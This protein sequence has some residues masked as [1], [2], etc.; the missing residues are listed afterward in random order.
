MQT[1]E[2]RAR[3]TNTQGQMPRGIKNPPMDEQADE[4]TKRGKNIHTED[5]LQRVSHGVYFL[6]SRKNSKEHFL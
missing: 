6:A 1:D 4:Q 3:S 2:D 5:N